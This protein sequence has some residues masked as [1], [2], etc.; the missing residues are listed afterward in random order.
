[1][2]YAEPRPYADPE[3][4]ARH[5]M[6]IANAVEPVQGQ[7]HIE[8]ISGPFLFRDKGSVQEYGAGMDLAIAKGWL[9]RHESGTFV[10]LT[11]AGTDLFA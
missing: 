4:A 9:I 8:K 6:E 11:Q 2:K 5:L 3:A 10:T 7:I 1:M